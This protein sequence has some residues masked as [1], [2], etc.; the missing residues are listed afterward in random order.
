[1]I[2]IESQNRIEENCG[3]L[4]IIRSFFVTDCNGVEIWCLWPSVIF[5]IVVIAVVVVTKVI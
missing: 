1:M 5:V 4:G 3:S 2:D